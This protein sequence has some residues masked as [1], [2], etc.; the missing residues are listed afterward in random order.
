MGDYAAGYRD[1]KDA[2]KPRLEALAA[3][4]SALEA[5]AEILEKINESLSEMLKLAI[6]G[7]DGE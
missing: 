6:Q 5:K 3:K 7:K 4:V 1:A 2:M